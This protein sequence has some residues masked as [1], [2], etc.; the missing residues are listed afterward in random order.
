LVRD[1]NPSLSPVPTHLP[2]A[3][4]S[5]AMALKAALLR[6]Q[7]FAQAHVRELGPTRVRDEYVVRLQVPVHYATLQRGNIA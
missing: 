5:S 4:S 3:T 2:T 7:L 6:N 1:S